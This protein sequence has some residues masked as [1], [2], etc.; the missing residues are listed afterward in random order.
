ME[1]L[2]NTIQKL[3]GDDKKS[4]LYREALLNQLK[5]LGEEMNTEVDTWYE[6]KMETSKLLLNSFPY[7][8]YGLQIQMNGLGLDGVPVRGEVDED[9][10]SQG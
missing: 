9:T 4:N 5:A 6:D 1:E 7:L 8:Y 10:V 3:G 2:R